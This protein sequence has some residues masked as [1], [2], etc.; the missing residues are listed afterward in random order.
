LQVLRK[1]RDKMEFDVAEAADTGHGPCRA[2]TGNY[3]P[4]RLLEISVSLTILVMV[5][6]LRQVRDRLPQQP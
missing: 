3:Q 5:L 4:E 1:A 2:M 6:L